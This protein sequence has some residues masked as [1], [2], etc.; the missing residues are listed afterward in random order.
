M[1]TVPI[2]KFLLLLI[3]SASLFGQMGGDSATKNDKLTYISRSSESDPINSPNLAVQD[4]L[5]TFPRNT[6]WQDYPVDDDRNGLYNRLVVDIG[7]YNLQET[8]GVY[9]IL[10]DNDEN[11]LGISNYVNYEETYVSLS[12][13][14]QPIH[15]SGTDGPY[16]L[17]AGLYTP[18]W[19]GYT[20]F[21]EI[22]FSLTYET[23][24]QSYNHSQFE[25]PRAM[26]TGFSD[27]GNDTDDDTFYDEIV[28]GIQTEVTDYG[29][30]EIW[31]S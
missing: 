7:Y 13:P 2:K 9:G 28:I 17:R 26:I 29:Y 14:G 31:S 19:W 15:A 6:T 10:L 18:G 12:F 16:V 5:S 22:N 1:E 27:Y 21:S 24:F 23:L 8:I 11:I 30:Y 20:D 25:R 4:E 3:L